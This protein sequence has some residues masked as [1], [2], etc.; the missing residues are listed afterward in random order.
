MK[1]LHLKF[2]AEHSNHPLSYSLFCTLRPYWIV[3]PTLADR[4][5]CMCKQHENPGF[6][7]KKLHQMHIL[8]T[9]NLESLTEVITCDTT[10]KHCMYGE[11]EKCSKKEYELT[12]HYR[13]TDRVSYNQWATMDKDHKD[14][15]GVS[16]KISLK[17]EFECSQEELVETCAIL[18]QNFR[19]YLFNLRQQYAFLRAL[20]LNLPVNDCV[21]HIDFSENYG[22]KY[23][24]EVQAVHFG[25]SHQQATLHT[26]VYYV[27]GGGVCPYLLLHYIGIQTE[28]AACHLATPGAHPGGN[29]RGLAACVN[30]P[31]F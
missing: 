27:G 31:F 29:S 9:S 22:C 19:R 28:G 4:E 25:A 21:V 15:P 23:S 14:N 2:L 3:H 8:D 6:I 5:T 12:S 18:L 24:S 17:K 13:A 20:K 26:G 7:A 16:S 1:N 10:D 30:H 11:C